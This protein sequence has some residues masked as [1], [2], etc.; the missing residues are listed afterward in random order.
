MSRV[1]P[2]LT[3][4]ADRPLIG[5]ILPNAGG[6]LAGWVVDPQRIK[7]GSGCRRTRS[8]RMTCASLLDYSRA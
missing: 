6:H 1:G 3:H 2:D 5:G 7:P 4:V 8:G